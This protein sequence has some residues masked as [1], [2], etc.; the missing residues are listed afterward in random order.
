MLIFTIFNIY[1]KILMEVNL[2]KYIRHIIAK[3][4][5]YIIH[6]AVTRDKIKQKCNYIE[7]NGLLNYIKLCRDCYLSGFHPAKYETELAITA[8]VKNE[9]AYIKEWIE[10]HKLVGVEKFF[11]YDNES[12]DNLYEILQPYIKSGEVIYKLFP[13]KCAQCSAYQDSVKTNRNKV[14]Y[15]AFIDIDEFITPVKYDTIPEFLNALENKAGRRIDAVGINWLMHG[16][17]GKYE[18]PDGLV[19]EN[20]KKCS[21]STPENTHIKSIVNLRTVI[22]AHHPHFCLHKAGAKIVNAFAKDFYGPFSLPLSDDI[23]INHYWSKSYKE[24]EQKI[25][26]GRATTTDKR[27]MLPFDP[28]YFSE[29]DDTSMDRFIPLLKNRLS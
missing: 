5:K 7:E 26:R 24:Y 8:I 17:N 3:S 12:S 15:M 29:D 19:I 2:N 6:N 14:K 13:G 4:S 28:Y 23:K 16:F 20:F 25:N 22:A 10:F 9:V 18:K 1:N 11:I 21:R 27:V